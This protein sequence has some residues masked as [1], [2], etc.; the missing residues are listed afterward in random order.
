MANKIDKTLIN[1]LSV[2]ARKEKK[3][4]GF[5]RRVRVRGKVA[6]KELTKK[7]N[8]KSWLSKKERRDTIL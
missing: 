4:K 8:I 1:T 6:K 3:V 2:L 5:K 7:G